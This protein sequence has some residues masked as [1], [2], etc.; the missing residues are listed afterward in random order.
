V[1]GVLLV[2]HA[3][4]QLGIGHLTRML[5]LGEALERRD[6]PPRLL[7]AGEPVGRSDLTRFDHSVV[8]LEDDLL[9]QVDTV[10]NSGDVLVFDLHPK[11]IPSDFTR[12]AEEWRARG[13]RV[14]GIDA[15]LSV[16]ASLDVTWVP[17]LLVPTEATAACADIIEFG[18]DSF[19]IKPGPDGPGSDRVLVLTGGSDVTGQAATLPS[20]IDSALPDGTEVWWVQGPFADAPVVPARPRLR[21]MVQQAPEGLEG[22]ITQ[23][24]Y[25]LTIF[26]VTLF[27]LL[28]AGMPTV[29][30]SPYEDREFPELEIVSDEDVAI[31]AESVPA[32]VLELAELVGDGHRAAELSATARSRMA[33]NGAD[34]L[35]GLIHSLGE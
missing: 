15:M 1:S 35:A 6:G 17:S 11:L 29:V 4:P 10:A 16:C 34:R 28:Q 18:W 9:A 5:A 19:L 7:L 33:V 8:S 30:F 22:L 14:V 12:R 3:G 27:E 25:A 2:C 32:A 23:C 26:G 31:V 21:W 20:L 13:H 24:G